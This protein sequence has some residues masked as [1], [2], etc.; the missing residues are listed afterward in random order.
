MKVTSKQE[1]WNKVNEIFPTDYAKDEHSS[2]RAGYPVYRSTAEGHHCDYICDL[3]DRLEV[4]LDSSHLETVNIWIEHP[5]QEPTQELSDERKKLAKRL[6]RVT[7]WFTGEY[8]KELA[9]KEKEDAAVKARQAEPDDGQI[10]CMVL[11][12]ENN[13]K[14]M[15]ECIKELVQ[16]VDIL[17]DREEDVDDWMLAGITAMLDKCNEQKVIPFDL[18]TSICGLLG[19]EWRK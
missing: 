3:G 5:A 1:A 17:T 14:V 18:P 8:V 4:N 7:F 15:L 12:A 13:A 2:N 16:A 6:Q 9:N 10:K 11:T 19:A